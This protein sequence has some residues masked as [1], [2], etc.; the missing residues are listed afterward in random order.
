MILIGFFI[1]CLFAAPYDVIAAQDHGAQINPTHGVEVQ[2]SLYLQLSAQSYDKLSEYEGKVLD[3]KTQYIT[4]KQFLAMIANPI[5]FALIDLPEGYGGLICSKPKYLLNYSLD[6]L[7]SYESNLKNV[8]IIYNNL[9]P[10]LSNNLSVSEF[11]GLTKNSDLKRIILI[12]YDQG[13]LFTLDNGEE[14]KIIKAVQFKNHSAL[15][16]VK[17]LNGYIQN[18]RMQ[19]VLSEG[20]R[21]FII[22]SDTLK[23]IQTR[24]QGDWETISGYS[25]TTGD[26]FKKNVNLYLYLNFRRLK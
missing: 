3:R 14:I 10:N 19:L 7:G 8:K 6:N 15:I 25:D 18:D 16:N 20:N 11:Q 4:K 5:A 21:I 22:D 23:L 13:T 12:D 17:L 26:Y 24:E 2:N 9:P 1:G